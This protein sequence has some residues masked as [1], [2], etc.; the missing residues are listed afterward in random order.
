MTHIINKASIQEANR[1]NQER[2]D[3]I[4]MKA[5]NITNDPKRAERLEA[6]L[7]LRCFYLSNPRL[8]GAAITT[9]DCGGCGTEM[10]FGSTATDAMCHSCSTSKGLCRQCGA[11][12]ETGTN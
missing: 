6:N 2:M 1:R 3:D 4:L 7:C 10:R 8:G 9:R 12:K 5:Q 11:E